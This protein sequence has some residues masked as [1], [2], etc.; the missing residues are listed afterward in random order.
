MPEEYRRMWADLYRFFEYFYQIYTAG[1][2]AEDCVR[3]MEV[4]DMLYHKWGDHPFVRE[5]L[6]KTTEYFLG[7]LQ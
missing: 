7:R 1:M 3:A 4:V 5:M 6:I 2:R